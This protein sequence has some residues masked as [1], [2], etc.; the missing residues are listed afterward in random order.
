MNSAAGDR[1]SEGAYSA[2]IMERGSE[3]AFGD[4]WREY[5][6]ATPRFIS[7]FGRDDHARP[8]NSH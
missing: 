3:K 6:A 2:S 7:H 5:A 4:A 8:V 1:G